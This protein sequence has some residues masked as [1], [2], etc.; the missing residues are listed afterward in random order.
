M[1]EL[2]GGLQTMR[3]EA[4]SDVEDHITAYAMGNDKITALMEAD[5]DPIT[6]DVLADAVVSGSTEQ[7]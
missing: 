3:K 2:V 5:E 7:P 4:G 6:S 1:R